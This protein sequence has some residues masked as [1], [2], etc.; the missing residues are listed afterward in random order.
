MKL[1][2]LKLYCSSGL[3]GWQGLHRTDTLGASSRAQGT[4]E[5]RAEEFGTVK[6]CRVGRSGMQ[7]NIRTEN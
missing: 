2:L 3:R 4:S 1:E 7:Q 5:K 6:N